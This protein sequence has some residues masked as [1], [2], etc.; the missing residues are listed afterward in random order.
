MIEIGGYIYSCD[1]QK[2]LKYHKLRG[3]ESMISERINTS[4]MLIRIKTT[5]NREY[6]VTIENWYK[7]YNK[8]DFNRGKEVF[9]EQ[10]ILDYTFGVTD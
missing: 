7:S 8:E 3:I 9:V 6:S 2:R 4:Y 10:V 1:T 5:N